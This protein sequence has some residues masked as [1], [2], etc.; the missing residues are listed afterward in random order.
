MTAK[1]TLQRLKLDIEY[2]CTFCELEEE[3]ICHLFFHCMAPKNFLIDVQHLIRRKTGQLIQFEDKYI[4][5]CFEGN[6]MD[7]DIVYFVQLILL[8]GKIPHSQE[9]MGGLQAKL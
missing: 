7:K 8:L 9:E 4:V 6:E 3:T 2:S 1:R 5:I